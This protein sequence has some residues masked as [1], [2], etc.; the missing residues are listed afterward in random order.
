MDAPR[1]PW[2]IVFM[3]IV[4]AIGAFFRRG[5]PGEARLGRLVDGRFGQGS[6]R[7]FIRVL[8]PEL[9][10]AAMCLGIVLSAL[11]RAFVFRTPIIPPEV[12]G[13]FASGSVAFL[14]AYFIRRRRE[15]A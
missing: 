14:A 2:L 5:H 12:M 6:Y 13:F 4:V 9:M 10:F 1:L 3:P 15:S 11:A 7:E 8:R